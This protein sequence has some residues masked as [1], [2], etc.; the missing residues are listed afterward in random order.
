[1]NIP[2]AY[3]KRQI[4]SL[5]A[6]IFDPMGLIGP[7]IV[8]AKWFMQMIW[9]LHVPDGNK[10]NKIDW[11]DKVPEQLPLG[12]QKISSNL[13]VLNDISVPRFFFSQ[14][15]LLNLVPTA[16]GLTSRVWSLTDLASWKHKSLWWHEQ[17]WPGSIRL[18]HS[19]NLSVKLWNIEGM[20]PD[21][22]RVWLKLC[23]H[24]LWFVFS[25]CTHVLTSS[26]FFFFFDIPFFN[27]IFQHQM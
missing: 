21:R 27:L 25:F 23:S 20:W 16:C 22:W 11:D 8:V 9:T 1:M 4:L 7:V 24:N 18:N 17:A 26:P 10:T 13:T 3:T 14:N 5:I 15:T 19:R 2:P 12:F 6:S